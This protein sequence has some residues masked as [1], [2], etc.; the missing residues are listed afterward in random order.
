MG[1][2]NKIIQLGLAGKIESL[3]A[4]GVISAQ[5]I[6]ARLAQDG[7]SISQPTISRWLKHQSDARR[8]TAQQLVQEHVKQTVPADLVALEE[9]EAQCLAWARETNDEFAH[10]LS[11]RCIADH[12]ES[13]ATTIQ[14][15]GKDIA[16]AGDEEEAE[17]VRRQAVRQIMDQCL[18]WIADDITL[19]KARLG[20][21]RMAAAIID[22]KLKHAIDGEGASNILICAS[23]DRPATP[24]TGEPTAAGTSR[25]LS[26]PGETGGKPC[27]NP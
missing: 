5:A 2:F 22:L 13:W 19:Q 27:A 4:E 9:M 3:I 15:A 23:E 12:L 26:F 21:M 7:Y 24:G 1:R 14:T 16:A 6:S 18:A 20:A 25:V 10:R 17:R 11:G 8:E